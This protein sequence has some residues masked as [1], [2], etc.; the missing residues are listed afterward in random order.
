MNREEAL[1]IFAA[2]VSEEEWP[3]DLPLPHNDI[4]FL[5]PSI[6][7]Q[8]AA[9]EVPAGVEVG[10][11]LLREDALET[12]WDGR[13]IREDDGSYRAYV[14]DEIS[15]EYW[16]GSVNA[17]LYLDLVHKCI[18]SRLDKLNGLTIDDFDNT[19]DNIV[20]LE[21]SFPVEGA[22]LNELFER[23]TRIQHD[24]EFPADLVVS[25]VTRALAASSERIL[26]GHYSDPPELVARVDA[27]ESAADKGSS[28]ELLM[29]A[30][31]AQVPGF[32]IFQRNL[33]TET[34][35]LDLVIMNGSSDPIF[36]KEESIIIVE[37]KNWTASVGRPNFSA[38]MDK[39]GQRRTR[40]SLAFLISWSGFTETVTTQ[41][42]R[43]SHDRNMIVCLAG[44]DIRRAALAGSFPELLR[45]ASISTV[46][47]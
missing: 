18:E 46:T 45:E 43:Y 41:S 24:L 28:L 16:L 1:A 32:L 17:R 29:E 5:P 44:E 30:L 21:Y 12:Y 11:G 20:R 31:F 3:D 47:M 2:Y 27:A 39:M 36:S 34:E 8:I 38:L 22:N 10:I 23:A 26:S 6:L 35:E 37:C 33:R 9:N 25:D 13:L 4:V 19:D 40:C 7:D 15:P 42:L 14:S